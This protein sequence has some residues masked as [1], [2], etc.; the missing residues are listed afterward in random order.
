MQFLCS[1]VLGVLSV[2][3][4]RRPVILLSNLGLGID[5]IFMALAPTLSLLFVGRVIS[6]I[7]SANI[8]AASAYISDV[9]PPEK[10]AQGFGM[11]GM[12]FGIGFILGPALGGVL[13]DINPHLP[14]WGAAGLSLV[15]T[16]YGVFV[17]PESLPVK[18][19]VKFEWKK[20]NPIGALNLLRS[21]QR[22]FRLAMVSFIITLAHVVLPSVFVLYATYRYG[23]NAKAIGL[24]LAGVGVCSGV[25]QG[26]LVGPIVK[27][28]GER[29]TLLLGLIFGIA[30]FAVSGSAPTGTL[31]LLGVPLLALWGLSSAVIQGMMTEHVAPTE[32]GRL[33]GANGS[34]R[35]IAELV[36]PGIFTVTFAIFITAERN[37]PGA[38]F[39]LSAVLL[40]IATL[41]AWKTLG[42]RA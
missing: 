35:G 1:P 29:N 28:L 37:L 10:R 30:G 9:T 12:A 26:G 27:H 19:R 6:G 38:P 13:G 31:F 42:E 36:G 34:L 41:V 40:M 18:S 5:Y 7:T 24:T 32:Q 23:W 22:L 21:H 3:F 39:F 25:V 17:L 33:Q 14:F 4:G 16:L 11:I 20:A 15:N 2:R 8:T